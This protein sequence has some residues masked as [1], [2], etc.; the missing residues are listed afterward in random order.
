M[1]KKYFISNINLGVEIWMLK[2]A[3]VIKPNSKT[4]GKMTFC[5]FFTLSIRKAVTLRKFIYSKI[6]FVLNINFHNIFQQIPRDV[7][8]TL[9]DTTMGKRY[10]NYY[11][12]ECS[13]HYFQYYQWFE[14][15][16]NVLCRPLWWP[17]VFS[18]YF[19]Y[20]WYS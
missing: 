20:S 8:W 7:S 13:F 9:I 1:K 11:N 17:H 15:S 16:S 19:I 2:K 3:N 5:Y 12:Y 6:R 4:S 10:F 18:I 14:C